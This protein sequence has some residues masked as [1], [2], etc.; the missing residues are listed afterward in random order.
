MNENLDSLIQSEMEQWGI[1]GL[2]VMFR[3]HGKTLEQR[4]YGFANLEHGVPVKAETVFQIGSIGKQFAATAVMLLVEAGK[5][6][7][8]APISRY[9]SGVQASW[10][11]VKV[12]H[13]LSHTA[14]VP[15]DFAGVD[16]RADL[17]E[18]ELL[19]KILA[20]TLEFTPGD[21]ISYSNDGYKLV[22]ILISKVS[23]MFYGDF[24]QQEI[25]QPLGMKIAQIIDDAAIIPNRAA[26]YVHEGPN[27][28][29]QDWV[30]PTFNSTADGAIYMTLEDFAHWDDALREG[31]ILSASSLE[32]MWTPMV[33][34]DGSIS[35][36]GFGWALHNQQDFRCVGHGG[37]WQGFTAHFFKSL[38][39][40][41]SITTLTNIADIN[42]ERIALGIL[43]L[44]NPIFTP[45]PE[46]E[47]ITDL[48][49]EVT[50]FAQSF[51]Q[52]WTAGKLEAAE[53]T[54]ELWNPTFIGEVGTFLTQQGS[55]PKL[56]VLARFEKDGLNVSR[57]RL[58]FAFARALFEIA[59]NDQGKIEYLLIHPA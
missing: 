54:T 32:Q 37:D 39:D 59:R 49:P 15:T 53:F 47:A 18:D 19:E 56:E 23:G 20:G 42:I 30:S 27:L 40:D 2:N 1:P 51:L 44:F 45:E 58:K 9:F 38:N 3:Q 55:E 13:L 33:R 11:G 7:L 12:K 6:D 5:I 36:Y 8:E 57:Y 35:N 24:L 25:F 26:G 52:R 34:N 14:G 28:R 16:L 48:E 50:A 41:L 22:G 4:S 21:Q 46:P 29:N 43:G 10:S 31:K 17:S